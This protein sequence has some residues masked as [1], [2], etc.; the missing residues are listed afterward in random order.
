MKL[1]WLGTAV[2]VLESGKEKILFDP[3]ME[4]QGGH[5]ALTDDELL[6]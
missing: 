1:T 5:V 3:F 2:F 4:L 6:Q